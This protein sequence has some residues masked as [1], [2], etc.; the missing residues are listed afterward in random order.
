MPKD[1]SGIHDVAGMSDEELRDLIVQQLEEHPAL[2]AGWIEVEVADGFVTLAGTVG[3]D[4]E[5]QISE[6]VIA[7]VLDADGY[8]NALVVNEL[9]RHETP[10][11][12]DDDL[13]AR[14]EADDHLGGET[15]QQS[16][17]AAHLEEDLEAET[18]GTRD[19][20]QSI[21]EGAT[22]LPPDRPIADG[23]QSEENH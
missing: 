15:R 7:Q 19:M 10:E 22:Y 14:S 9:H 16:D 5:K 8:E 11:A 21:Q 3:T 2:D 4:G 18:F 13:S 6:S 12:S 23:Y 20:Q 1:Y 17:T